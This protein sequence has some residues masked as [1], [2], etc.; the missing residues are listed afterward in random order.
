V[1]WGYREVDFGE[2]LQSAIGFPVCQAAVDHRAEGYARLLGWVQTVWTDGV[3][4]LDP[5][6]PFDGLDLP[7]CWIGF[8]PDLFDTPWRLDRDRDLDWEAH[9]W[10]C[11]PPASLI[12]REVGM[13]CGFQ[14]GYRLRGGRVENWGPEPLG[15]KAWQADLPVLRAA[16]PSWSFASGA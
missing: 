1:R 6:A 7:Y 10:L 15:L 11:G 9:S 13:L 12:K 3:G 14:W 5:W 16:C 2:H 4:A 8:V